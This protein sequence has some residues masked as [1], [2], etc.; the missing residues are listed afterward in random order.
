VAAKVE[1]KHPE[2]SCEA[3]LGEPA[4]PA[5]MPADAVQTDDGRRV[6]LAPFVHVQPHPQRLDRL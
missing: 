6:R 4:E 3:P 1:G 5:P 2:S